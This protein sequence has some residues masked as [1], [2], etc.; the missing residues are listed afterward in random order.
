MKKQE[1]S[2]SHKI[3]TVIGTIMC[4]ILIPI[5]VINCTLIIKSYTNKE[6]VPSVGGVFPLIVLTDSMYPEIHAGDLIICN[7]YEVDEI[8][9]GDIIAFFDPAGN[10]TSIVTHR[11]LEVT[12]QDGEL[13]FKTKGDANN[14]ED[15]MLVPQENFVGLYKSRL[16]GVGN[17]AMF[18][19]STTGLIVC[20]VLPI[21]LLVAYDV[22]RRRMYEKNKKDDMAALKAELEALKAEKAKK[23]KE[24][25]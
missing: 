3:M 22:I 19:Q 13:A 2:A 9:E 15:K 23:E 5:L 16:P 18:M 24:D 8:K 10:G 12:E 6:E 25:E 1:T 11:V 7:N 17:I 4:I 20:V 21:I 14:V